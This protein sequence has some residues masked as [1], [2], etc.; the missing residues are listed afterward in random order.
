MVSTQHASQATTGMHVQ[1]AVPLVVVVV[2]KVMCY[3]CG[4]SYFVPSIRCKA[5]ATMYDLQS[6][7][8]IL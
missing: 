1:Q 8:M 3:L 4:I 2:V 5:S 7:N 6:Y